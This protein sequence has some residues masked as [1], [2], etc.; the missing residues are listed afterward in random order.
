[1]FLFLFLQD[2][3]EDDDAVEHVVV[4]GNDA[5][6]QRISTGLAA[7]GVQG[8]PVARYEAH[9]K[10]SQIEEGKKSGSLYTVRDI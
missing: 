7:V 3:E 9:L 4:G 5:K 6:R 8:K 10:L 2:V 1:M